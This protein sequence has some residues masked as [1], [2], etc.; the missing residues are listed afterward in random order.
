MSRVTK[1]CEMVE[2]GDHRVT[3][4]SRAGERPG[5]RLSRASRIFLEV[6]ELGG[7]PGDFGIPLPR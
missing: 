5:P 6:D 3:P 7:E 4:V 1:A 2:L